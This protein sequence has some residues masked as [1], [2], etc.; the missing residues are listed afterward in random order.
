LIASD[1]SLVTTA[2]VSAVGE[3]TFTLTATDGAVLSPSSDTVKVYVYDDACA[4][5]LADPTDYTALFDGDI[6]GD[7]LVDL[8]DFAAMATDW[9]DCASDKLGCTP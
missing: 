7:C 6:T 1:A 8:N 5:A 9:L 2:T 4:A 3:Y